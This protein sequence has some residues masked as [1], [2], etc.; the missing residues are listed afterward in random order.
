MIT[1]AVALLLA[2]LPEI[3]TFVVTVLGAFV[4]H[5]T[6]AKS[7]VALAVKVAAYAL[8]EVAP[9]TE[10]SVD[11]KLAAVLSALD[12]AMSDTGKSPTVVDVEK[13]KA[14][15]AQMHTTTT[16]APEAK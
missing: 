12:R 15:F 4:L 6:K 16:P 3:A 5:T 9:R 2:H 7:N 1:A 14:V 11:D 10:T 8:S 13:A